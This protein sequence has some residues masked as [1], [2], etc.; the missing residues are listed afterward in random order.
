[1]SCQHFGPE[2]TRMHSTKHIHHRANFARWKKTHHA[3]TRTF[4]NYRH[5]CVCVRVLLSACMRS[6]SERE[7]NALKNVCAR[8]RGDPVTDNA[9]S[10]AYACGFGLA[11]NCTHRRTLQRQHSAHAC[12]HTHTAAS[13]SSN[14]AHTHESRGGAGGEHARTRRRTRTACALAQ[15]VIKQLK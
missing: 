1:M 10:C 4:T 8:A 11:E 12:T 13:R 2:H 9:R 15:R 3:C 6:R 7:N 14:V 5:A